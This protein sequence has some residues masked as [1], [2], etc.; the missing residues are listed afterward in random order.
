M[1]GRRSLK[2]LLIL[3]AAVWICA[4]CSE[5]GGEPPAGPPNLV[6]ITVDTLRADRLA[7]YGGAVGAGIE[8]CGL[9][10]AGARYTW[11]V[12]TA[13][14]TAPSIASI[15][16]S[17]YPRDHGVSQFGKT[18]LA[19]EVTTVAELLAEAGYATGAV[20]SNPVI[21]RPRNLGQGFEVYDDRMTRSER[22]RQNLR[23]R[24]AGEAS[25]AALAW[26][27]EA[28]P[29]WFLWIH[30]QDPHG[31]YEPP[32]AKPARDAPA[33]R[34]LPV[35]S[36][37]S[38]R[39]GI[40][41]YQALTGVFTL[42][43]YEWR[44]AQEI[45]YLERHVVD[46]IRSLDQLGR[47]PGV[48]LTADHGEAFGEDGFYLAH[49]H[50]VG[51]DQIHVPLLWRPPTPTERLVIETPVSTLDVAP[52]LLEAA[53]IDVPASFRGRPLPLSSANPHPDRVLFAEH[54]LRIAA[55]SGSDYYG[56]DRKPMA[57]PVFDDVTGG[58]LHPI[59]PRLSTLDA[60]G[61]WSAYEA[62]DPTAPSA[63][64]EALEAGVR[65]F[66]DV[67]ARQRELR[68][69]LDPLERSAL[70]ALGYLE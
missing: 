1:R 4:G 6:L 62:V 26:A 68:P 20:I 49:G 65:D 14:S 9:F 8:L 5:R 3:G 46:L 27:R 70:R 59:E 13:P 16:T 66:L 48:L 28:Q 57:S 33:N 21:R 42:E 54:R 2:R 43:A 17:L 61:K 15:L 22:V 53:G 38:G 60:G 19:D 29:P 7:C 34:R 64:A 12:S 47:P 32:N 52:T 50:S 35:L 56:R 30:Y 24:E 18:R 37:Q 67:T 51:L 58:E 41:A 36:D 25:Q 11:A 40:P 31:P 44:Y 69:E 55:I 39:D 45:Q 23:E 10:D 63:A